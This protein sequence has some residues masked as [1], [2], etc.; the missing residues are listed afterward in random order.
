M[1][2]IFLDVDTQRDFVERG[3]GLYAEGAEAIKPN[4]QR[5]VTGAHAAGVPLV[6]C[7]DA[8]P[9]DDPEFQDWPPHAV[10][11]TPGQAKVQETVTGRE[12]VVPSDPAA[13]LPDPRS[14]HVVLE[15][16]T[17]SVFSNPHAPAVFERAGADTVAVFGVVTEVCVKQ[18]ALGLLERGYAVRLVQDAIWP[19]TPEGGREALAELTAK[20]ATLTTTAEL[21]ESL[22]V[23]RA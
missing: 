20:G 6:S 5:L 16:Q 3:G 13:S 7:V 1:S 8:H 19:I 22:E 23:A 2:L 21:L 10:V 14:A 18:A 15:K 12:V 17:F 9:A 4:L 11:G